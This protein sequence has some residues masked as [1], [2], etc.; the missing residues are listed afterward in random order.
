MKILAKPI[1]VISYT[2]NNG[3]LRP[4]R[5]RIIKEDETL[6]VIRIDRI[7]RKITER[8]AGNYMHAFTCQSIINNSEKVYELKY[9][10]DTCKWIL[11]KI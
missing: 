10:L 7:I 9:E 1:E 8:I 5:F 6:E 4:L 2:D 11:F 3:N